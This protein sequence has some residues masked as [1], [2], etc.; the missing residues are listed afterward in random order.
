MAPAGKTPAS[1]PSSTDVVIRSSAM[2]VVLLGVCSS[3]VTRT[4]VMDLPVSGRLSSLLTQSVQA[5]VSPTYA[6]PKE[7]GRVRSG[8][9]EDGFV[10]SADEYA[11][12]AWLK[13]S[14]EDPSDVFGSGVCVASVG[15]ERRRTLREREC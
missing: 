2:P 7:A 6:A 11:R 14:R 10:E 1:A 8:V 4:A 9:R 15:R 3:A 13:I 5:K 12:D